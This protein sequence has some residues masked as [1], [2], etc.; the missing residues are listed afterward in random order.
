M[1]RLWQQWSDRAGD[2]LAFVFLVL[3]TSGLLVLAGVV[4]FAA[5]DLIAYAGVDLHELA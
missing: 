2:G 1:P 4:V 5:L 3:L